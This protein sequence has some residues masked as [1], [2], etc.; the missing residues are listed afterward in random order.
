[1]SRRG[2]RWLRNLP[3][4]R[5]V[6]LVPLLTLCLMGVILGVAI[7]NARANTAALENL[8]RHAILPARDAAFLMDRITLTHGRLFALLSK[9]AN[10]SDPEGWA[11]DAAAVS[12][13]LR[14]QEDAVRTMQER[15]Q[16]EIA[17]NQLDA[18]TGAYRVYADS[19][20]GTIAAASSDRSYGALEMIA[21][22]DHFGTL[23]ALLNN[24]VIGLR[25]R[26]TMLSE[27]MIASGRFAESTMIII[28][29]LA[30]LLGL[31]GS[32]SVGRGITQPIQSLTTVIERL[33]K[34]DT[35][36][37]PPGTVR[38]DEV[39]AIARAV[40][41]FRVNEIARQAADA[42]LRR[43]HWQRD[44]ALNNM[45]HGLCL[46]SPK[47]E[48]LLWN[49]RYHEVLGLRPDIM[50]EGVPYRDLLTA[51]VQA[52]LNL[53]ESVESTYRQQMAAV[54]AG[55]STRLDAT[56]ENGRH[57]AICRNVL[58]EGGWVATV[59]D[60]TEKRRDEERIVYMARHDHL[61]GLP[62][63]RLFQERLELALTRAARGTLFAVHCL[64][65]DHFKQ[66]NDT[67]G[68]DTGDALLRSIAER[69]Q[70]CVREIDT[71]ARLGGDEF[72]IL[73]EDIA[74]TESAALL[75][76][77]ILGVICG[78][79]EANGHHIA[80]G[81]SLGIAMAPEHGSSTGALLK[82]AD[83]ALY[84][85]KAERGRFQFFEPGMAAHL[86]DRRAM[87]MD[88]R[89]AITH[90]E[91]ELY[92]QPLLALDRDGE[93]VVAFEAL[94]RWHH[95]ERGIVSPADFIPLAEETGLILPIGEWVLVTACREAAT[96]PDG[97]KVA[98]NLSPVQ[99]RGNRLNA[100]IAQALEES[101]LPPHRLDVEITE[102]ILLS[103]DEATLDMLHRVRDLGVGISMD[104]FGTGY[105]SLS[106][107]H[108]FPFDKIKI[109]RSFITDITRKDG[110]RELVRA[111]T[112]L[113]RG[114]GMTTV[115]EGVE[116]DEQLRLLRLE[117][118]TEV[119]GYLFSPP[120]PA[121]KVRD[122]LARIN[123]MTEA[124]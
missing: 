118:C 91:F 57:V 71:V 17:I 111:I 31:L 101:R 29:T 60:T 102:S 96:W 4:A 68:H 21:A 18:L 117:G 66:I 106:Y 36:H 27:R 20:A 80:T 87:E 110:G 105:S 51:A 69:L 35:G 100:M 123:S 50:R 99:F 89:H 119:Q 77:R 19:A 24:T 65:L 92:Y 12:R 26:R 112:A 34:G 76:S 53:L 78:T 70:A 114:L 14:E 79:M 103:D 122:I 40:E 67:L 120:V 46:F 84:A 75:A 109:D 73:Q 98:V 22:D 74:D 86:R 97:V 63:R 82:N 32:A 23:R 28:G 124:V 107:L 3:L 7:F 1:M 41:V 56:M 52:G 49:R 44:V 48:L 113:S 15:L 94:I 58:P 85:A 54:A 108:K 83:V 88:L 10:E 16:G 43:A 42:A 25:D 38:R 13:L 37:C 33:A 90:R 55:Q 61:T 8:E 93:H 30:V 6:V 45:S 64:D 39:G 116:T 59:E 11:R 95:P 72:A 47:G 104:D 121:P 2:A 81:A 5:K 9:R 62:N 115:A